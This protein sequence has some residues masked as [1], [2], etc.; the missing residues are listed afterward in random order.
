MGQ[1][2]RHDSVPGLRALYEPRDLYV[3]AKFIDLNTRKQGK[4]PL[5]GF[6]VGKGGTPICAGGFPMVNWRYC[7]SRLRI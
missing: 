3:F 6:T 7:E 2:S 5:P 1:V 4:L